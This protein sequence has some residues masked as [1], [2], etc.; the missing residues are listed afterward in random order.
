M[1]DL[2]KPVNPDPTYTC[3]ISICIQINNA[4]LNLLIE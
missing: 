4:A 2:A 1:K 3:T